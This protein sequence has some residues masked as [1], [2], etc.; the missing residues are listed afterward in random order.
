MS[1]AEIVNHHAGYP[2]CVGVTGL[3]AGVAMAA[4]GGGAARL[5]VDLAGVSAA[6]RVVDVGC[7]P[8]NA[9]RAAA[10]AGA[11][12]TG[13][14]PSPEMLRLARAISPRSAGIDWELGAA[15]RLPVPDASAT[16]LW[17]IASV[18]HWTD[19]PAGLAEARRVLQP[20][21]RLLVIERQ[22]RADASGLSSH[23]WTPRQA[24]AFA[25]M[26]TASGFIDVSVE[27]RVRRRRGVA[28]SAVRP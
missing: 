3:L 7:G 28:V 1:S 2:G 13:V 18:H 4:F 9:A 14:D 12:V 23:G 8:G 11:R 22:I 19:V 26:C 5:V 16:V 20:G 27:E 25:R 17:T 24:E 21:G 15:E 10:R 6:D